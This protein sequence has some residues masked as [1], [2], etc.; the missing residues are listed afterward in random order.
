[1]RKLLYLTVLLIAVACDKEEH[2][3]YWAP[4]K[5]YIMTPNTLTGDTGIVWRCPVARVTVS[6][7]NPDCN[8][9]EPSGIDILN[10]LK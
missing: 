10:L 5:G 9:Y 4:V 6:G 3:D 8:R 1:M 7:W 2:Y